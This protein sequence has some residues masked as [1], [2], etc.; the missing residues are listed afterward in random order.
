MYRIRFIRYSCKRAVGVFFIISILMTGF[1]SEVSAEAIVYKFGW[2]GS[3]SITRTETYT[4]MPFVATFQGDIGNVTGPS[5][6]GYTNK[7]LVGTL[8]GAFGETY[9]LSPDY[10]V[11]IQSPDL[12][13]AQSIGFGSTGSGWLLDT[14]AGGPVLKTYD[15][16]SSIGPISTGEGSIYAGLPT[17]PYFNYTN[18]N[19]FWFEAVTSNS[20]PVP[21]PGILIL[22]GI[23]IASVAGL[24]RWCKV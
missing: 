17:I 19:N 18:V 21:E 8:T 15:L 20:T 22:L 9:A 24:K 1:T 11:G 16:K 6:T 7:P 14:Y 2:T 5:T 12:G 3:S 10:Y 4:D 13:L 23:S